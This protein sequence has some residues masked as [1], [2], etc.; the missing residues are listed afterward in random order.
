[1]WTGCALI[2]DPKNKTMLSLSFVVSWSV[3]ED[4][5]LSVLVFFVGVVEEFFF[6]LRGEQLLKTLASICHATILTDTMGSNGIWLS[7]KH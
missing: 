7:Y 1:M 2:V 3:V 4:Q 5:F 6:F